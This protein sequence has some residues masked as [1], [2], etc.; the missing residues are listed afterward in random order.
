MIKNII[1]DFDGVIVDSEILAAKAYANYFNKLGYTLEEEEFYIYSGMKTFEVIDIL[2]AKY[3]IIDKNKFTKEIFE[4][5]SEIFSNQLKPVFGIKKYLQ[6]LNKEIYIGSNS[7]KERIIQGLKIVGLDNFFKINNIYSF[8]MV[9]NPKPYPDIYLKILND[10][11]LNINET[12]IIED[13]EI[14]VKAAKSAGIKVFGLT[15]GKHW[16]L[17]KNLSGLYDN[18]AKDVF[19]NYDEVDKAVEGL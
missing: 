12:I 5:I 4:N 14:G 8:D 10:N 1:F 16:N 7:N 18:G 13:S 9:E 19:D 2:T 17:N 6:K 15:A 3:N 11:F